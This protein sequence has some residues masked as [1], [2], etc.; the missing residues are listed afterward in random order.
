MRFKDSKVFLSSNISELKGQSFFY[1]NLKNLHKSHIKL[2]YIFCK[3]HLL[4]Y[5]IQLDK[6]KVVSMRFHSIWMRVDI[7]TVRQAHSWIENH[8]RYNFDCHWV[9]LSIDFNP[10]NSNKVIRYCSSNIKI[11]TERMYYFQDCNFL[12]GM[13]LKGHR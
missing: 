12:M 2:I 7:D 9:K 5:N 6:I 4:G 8:T 13:K 3:C 11:H 10:N 1:R